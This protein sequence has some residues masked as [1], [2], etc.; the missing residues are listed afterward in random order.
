M[1]ANAEVGQK[2]RAGRPAGGYIANPMTINGHPRITFDPAI[3]GG[4]PTVA[5]TRVRVSDVL[6]ILA[7]GAND[8]EILKDFPYLSLEDIRACSIHATQSP[9]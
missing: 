6:E 7:G 1:S 4:R 2:L 9:N 3:C 8:A 5:G